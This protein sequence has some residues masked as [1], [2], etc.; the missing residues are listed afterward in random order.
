[1]SSILKALKRVEAESPPPLPYQS[2]SRPIDS[3]QALNTNAKKRWHLRRLIYLVLILAVIAGSAAV[4]FSQRELL[5]AG[6][7]FLLPPDAPSEKD[8]AE[9]RTGIYRAKVPTA[10]S[11]AKQPQRNT[12]RLPTGQINTPTP[13]GQDNTFQSRATAGIQRSVDSTAGPR[14]TAA[15]TRSPQTQRQAKVNTQTKRVAT[16]PTAASL[17]KPDARKK[18]EATRPVAR[19]PQPV[20]PKPS[21]TYDRINDAKLRLQALAW[22]DDAA[23]R[24]V[25][26]NGR[27]V[28]EGESVDGYQIIK[29]REED[30]IIQQ[31]GKSWRLEFG[32]QQ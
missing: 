26:I 14:Q 17:R 16:P 28:H 15:N 20:R 29:I 31:A 8:P 23:R 27:I 32:L 13:T 1:M 24:M 2:L 5:I 10:G 7:S 25:V 6:L 11:V 12:A 4:V 18:P 19:T 21:R 9:D 3:K 30:V 22:A